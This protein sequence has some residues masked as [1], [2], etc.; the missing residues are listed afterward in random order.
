LI[1]VAKDYNLSFRQQFVRKSRDE[2]ASADDLGLLARGPSIPVSKIVQLRT[3]RMK[4]KDTPIMQYGG[5][6]AT[7]ASPIQNIMQQF[8]SSTYGYLH[9]QSNDAAAEGWV[10]LQTSNVWYLR[11]KFLYVVAV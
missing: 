7:S 11:H 10:P 1:K 2:P 6:K 5:A 8:D 3:S 9:R 4:R